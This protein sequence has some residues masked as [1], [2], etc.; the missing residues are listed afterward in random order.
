MEKFLRRVL[1]NKAFLESKDVKNFIELNESRFAALREVKDGSNSIFSSLSKK[2]TKVKEFV[3]ST[4]EVDDW[5]DNQKAYIQQIEEEYKVLVNKSKS[6]SLKEKDSSHVWKD[7]SETASILATEESIHDKKLSKY[8]EK[9]SEIT[10]Q[11]A[12]LEREIYNKQKENF[13][14]VI[15]DQLDLFTPVKNILVDRDLDLYLYQSSMNTKEIKLEKLN[16]NPD[17]MK[18]REDLKECELKEKKAK[19]QFEKTSEVVREELNRFFEIRSKESREAFHNLVQDMMNYHLAC[20][21][22]WKGM[23]KSIN[24]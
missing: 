9:M 8:F 18:L 15:S 11:L 12:N 14:D 23:L 13:E 21:D 24:E 22:T 2:I 1:S 7:M 6:I 5:Y 4:F 20:A 17:D 16:K 19:K 10:S 3:G